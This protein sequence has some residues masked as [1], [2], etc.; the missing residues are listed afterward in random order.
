M[1][2]IRDDASDFCI[3]ECIYCHG[4]VFIKPLPSNDRKDTHVDIQTDGRKL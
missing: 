3:A 1:D 2:R 4:N